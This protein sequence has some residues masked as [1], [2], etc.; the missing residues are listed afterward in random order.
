[1]GL[2]DLLSWLLDPILS[3]VNIHWRW[4]LVI[5]AISLLVVACLV[6]PPAAYYVM[7]LGLLT[8]GVLIFSFGFG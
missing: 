2:D 1:M 3:V 7:A 6:S 4:W 8:V 5:L